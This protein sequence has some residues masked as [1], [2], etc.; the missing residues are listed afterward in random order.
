MIIVCQKISLT[1]FTLEFKGRKNLV[2]FIV[3]LSLIT[4]P[5]VNP[6]VWISREDLRSMREK[7]LMNAPK[8]KINSSVHQSTILLKCK[9]D[10]IKT[11][12]HRFYFWGYY[13]KVNAVSLVPTSVF[14]MGIKR[15]F[16][17]PPWWATSSCPISQYVN[18]RCG[19]LSK[20]PLIACYLGKCREHYKCPAIGPSFTLL[21]GMIFWE[22]EG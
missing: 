22:Y 7:L 17:A 8:E 4:K 10:Y 6:E 2:N 1:R 15:T 20:M 5:C 12:N 3:F 21:K 9:T 18:L 13:T 19:K 11:S 14:Y 16:R